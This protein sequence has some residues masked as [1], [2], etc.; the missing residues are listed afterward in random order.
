M[1]AAA[2][3]LLLA[4]ACT[5]ETKPESPPS[6]TAPPAASAP[7]AAPAND[8]CVADCVAKNQMRATSPEQIELECREQCA[9]SRP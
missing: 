7:D 9:G 3:V 4:V 2:A 6:N 1:R 5:R 8:P